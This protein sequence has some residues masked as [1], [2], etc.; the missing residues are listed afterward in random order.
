MMN[1]H[2]L[3]IVKD[4]YASLQ[5]AFKTGQLNPAKMHLSERVVILSPGEKFEGKKNVIEMLQNKLIPSVK[6]FEFIHQFEDKNTICT[7]LDCITK[8]N[9]HN[10]PCAEL[11]QINDG[12]IKEIQLFYDRS[13]W[14]KAM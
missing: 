11:I 5:Q 10:I 1:R 6:R 7:I 12:L 9:G 8:K 3:E 2:A 4:Y 14:E 13:Q